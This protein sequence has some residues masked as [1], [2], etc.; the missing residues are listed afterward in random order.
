MQNLNLNLE[1]KNFPKIFEG[2]K[3][4]FFSLET[5][6]INLKTKSFYYLCGILCVF[7]LS[8]EEKYLCPHV[9]R[10]IG[11][12]HYHSHRRSFHIHYSLCIRVTTAQFQYNASQSFFNLFFFF[13][14]YTLKKILYFTLF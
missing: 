14:I 4:V 5:I 7:V 12:L 11:L 3:N 8:V 13:L 9:D 10:Q 1:I 2:K 6:N